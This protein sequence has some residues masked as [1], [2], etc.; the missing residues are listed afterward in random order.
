MPSCHWMAAGTSWARVIRS[1]PWERESWTSLGQNQALGAAHELQRFAG[2]KR[3][4][5]R[6]RGPVPGEQEAGDDPLLRGLLVARHGLPR[7]EL[8]L[9]LGQALGEVP[10]QGLALLEP[11][12][13]AEFQQLGHQLVFMD[14]HQ[15]D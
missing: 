10:Q 15:R 1:P 8:P 11:L 13:G 7:D 2:I 6:A 12:R 14:R 4:A 9:L 5:V 3:V